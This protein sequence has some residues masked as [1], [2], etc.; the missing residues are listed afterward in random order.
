MTNGSEK[1]FRYLRAGFNIQG[2][3]RK[4]EN[5]IIRFQATVLKFY[6]PSLTLGPDEYRQAMDDLI[7]FLARARTRGDRVEVKFD[8][9]GHEWV[10]WKS[11]AQMTVCSMALSQRTIDRLKHALAESSSDVAEQPSLEPDEL[12]HQ[13]H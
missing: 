5:R 11:P 10:E 8:H 4:G 1:L 9:F 7:S 2:C 6:R 13:A 3:Q 12:Q